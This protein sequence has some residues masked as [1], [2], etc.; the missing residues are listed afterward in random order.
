MK[1]TELA[2]AA[3][4]WDGEGTTFTHLQHYKAVGG[5]VHDYRNPSLNVKQSGT[6]ALLERF[7][8]ALGGLGKIYGPYKHSQG[9]NRKDVYGWYLNDWRLVQQALAYVWSY[10]GDEKKDQAKRVFQE[11]RKD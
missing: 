8:A 3:G 9:G 5:A 4:F 11:C 1:H 6:K 10:L 2:W 7:Q